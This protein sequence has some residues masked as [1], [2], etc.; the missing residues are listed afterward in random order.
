MYWYEYYGKR[1][2]PDHDK[3]KIIQLS[4]LSNVH[5][6]LGNSVHQTI[7]DVLKNLQI[8]GE[9]IS[10][11]EAKK[12][13]VN[14]FEILVNN[15]PLVEKRR[16]TVIPEE[17]WEKMRGQAMTSMTSFYSSRWL[18]MIQEM[19]KGIWR[20]WLVD[21]EGYGEFRLDGKKAYAKPDFVFEYKDGRHYLVEWKTGKPHRDI[22]LVQVQAYIFYANDVMKIPLE[23][24]VGVV[25]FLTYKTEMPIVVEGRLV[26]PLEIKNKVLSEIKM[27]E[28]QC[29]DV[30]S[31]VPKAIGHFSKTDDL[32]I[33][34]MCKFKEICRPE[35]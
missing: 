9:L 16:G 35:K 11:D 31:N 15:K 12:A 8:R 21:P 2:A 33:C 28:S 3:N 30:I 29:I 4:Q 27:I 24:L 22:N 10:L 1:H 14:K 20:N 18:T 5:F 6:E 25:E 17:E 19:P 13:A 23:S 34:V 7:S 32:A 26:N